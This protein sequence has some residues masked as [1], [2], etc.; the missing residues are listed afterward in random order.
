M[1]NKLPADPV[2]LLGI[3]NTKL[4]DYYRTL[5]DLC[6]DMDISRT[7]LSGRLKMIDYEYDAG[8]N[9]FI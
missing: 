2:I 6:D 9:Q 4:R 1:L 7:E 3:I 5:D 8:R